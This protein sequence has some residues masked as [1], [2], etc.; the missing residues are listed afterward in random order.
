MTHVYSAK[1]DV[2]REVSSC[3]CTESTRYAC[4]DVYAMCIGVLSFATWCVF[5]LIDRMWTSQLV[6][7]HGT[8]LV[9]QDN[10]N[11]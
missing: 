3:A 6:V 7:V 4:V 8:Q 1:C 11:E 10:V 2:P 5:A 9:R